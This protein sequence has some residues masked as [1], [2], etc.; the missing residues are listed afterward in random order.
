M[1]L[2]KYAELAGLSSR[3]W[4]EQTKFTAT[5]FGWLIIIIGG[6]I[7]AGIVFLPVQIGLV[8]IWVYILTA[9]IA[10]PVLYMYQRLYLRVMAESSE[11]E[12]FASVISEYL[13][14][15]WG[16]FLGILY[17]VFNAILLFLYSTALINDSSSFLVTFGISETELSQN[18]FYGLA[19]L[20]GMVLLA[21]QG[22]KLL[23]K[24]ATPMV[25]VKFCTIAL[26]GLVMVQYWQFSNIGAIPYVA[27]L[28]K[29]AI[30]ILPIVTMSLAF[31]TNMGPVLISYRR[32]NKNK[33]V[34]YYQAMRVMRITFILL[35]VMFFFYTISFNLAM[36]YEQAVE[37]YEA[38]ISS[39]AMAAKNMDGAMVKIFSLVL[40]IFAVM[41]AFFAVFLAF[42]DS[43][44]GIAMNIM[45]R[46][47]SGES[48]Y[49][50]KVYYGI[51][52][53]CILICWGA[54]M[55]NA[56]VLSFASMLGPLMGLIGCLMPVYLVLHKQEF[57]QYRNWQLCP[58]ALIGSF[59]IIST[60]VAFLQ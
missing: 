45:K 52:V 12:S 15:N 36:N 58:I 32:K 30:V 4:K 37:A 13:G 3:E 19:V 51:S 43:C 27:Y 54:V 10:Y 47:A 6:T 49:Q 56:P 59:L 28:G 20:C 23:F 29:Q 16:F 48:A 22:E 40:N 1:T 5:D 57:K 24:V 34:A 33:V 7:G 38:N 42:R 11:C 44:I 8:G 35:G 53:F 39:L 50:T 9:A 26:L 31:F 2:E 55:M 25:L 41:T 17:F 60:F 14:E 21:S 18:I 46:F